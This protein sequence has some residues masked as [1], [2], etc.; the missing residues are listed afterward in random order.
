DLSMRSHL[1]ISPAWCSRQEAERHIPMLASWAGG[2]GIGDGLLR[3]AGIYLGYGGDSEISRILIDGL[4][5]TG[6]AGFAEQAHD[7]QT[8][9]ALARLARSHGLRINTIVGGKLDELLDIWEAID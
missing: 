3:V 5:Y 4:P 1:A 6:W 7:A 8:Y 2:A 9:R